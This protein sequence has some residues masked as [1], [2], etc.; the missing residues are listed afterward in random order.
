MAAIK[1]RL[2]SS[3]TF[4]AK[5]AIPIPGAKPEQV[6]FTFKHMPRTEFL[7][8]FD[9]ASGMENV[10][11]VLAIAS[12]WELEDPFTTE[13]VDKLDQ[14]YLGAARAIYDTWRDQL[15][16]SRLGN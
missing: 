1:F 14:Q 11:I 6:E 15:T 2:N 13:N 3:P 16:G 10:E 7:E 8:F 12:G 5:V 4:K 9:K